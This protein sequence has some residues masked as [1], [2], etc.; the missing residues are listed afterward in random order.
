MRELKREQEE[1]ITVPDMGM[2]HSF[3]I[4]GKS[5]YRIIHLKIKTNKSR[6]I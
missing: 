3:Y 1:I 6:R 2:Y 4:F 5:M